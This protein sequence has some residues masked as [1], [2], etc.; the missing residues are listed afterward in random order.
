MAAYRMSRAPALF[1]FESTDWNTTCHIVSWVG[2]CGLPAVA[3]HD[4]SIMP[5]LSPWKLDTQVLQRR[6]S[7]EAHD[8]IP[9]RGIGP[10]GE[11]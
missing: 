8:Q 3:A 7:M 11:L 5:D 1:Q 2:G 4:A 6:N 10:F 9:P